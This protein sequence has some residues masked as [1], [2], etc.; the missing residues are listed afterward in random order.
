MSN[1]TLD[2]VP[3][4]IT[5]AACEWLDRLT[6]D[7]PQRERDAFVDWLLRSPIHVQ[8]F[9][10]VSAVHAGLCTQL[11]HNPSWLEALLAETG[12]NVVD[13][14][15]SAHTQAP[16]A[17]SSLPRRWLAL[18]A[19]AVV[20]LIG[21]ILWLPGAHD[22]VIATAIG[23]QR[24][25]ILADGSSIHL[26]T[27]TR[28]SINLSETRRD[29]E[30]E[31]GELMVKVAYDPNRPFTVKSENITAMALGTRFSVYKRSRNTVV[32][33]IEG[34][35]VV[36]R[37][38]DKSSNAGIPVQATAVELS[39]GLKTLVSMDNTE[40][41]PEPANLEATTAW[42]QRQLQF[43]DET[44]D[45]V[46]A[47]FNRYNVKQLIIADAALSTRRISGVFDANDPD[48]FVRLLTSL[49][50]IRVADDAQGRRMLGKGE[51][52]TKN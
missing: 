20:A 21:G 37:P 18:A 38:T 2:K 30:L 23:E 5:E 26:N 22:D 6:D 42:M 35:V 47:E 46:V 3:I 31:H 4:E 33:V 27:N 16:R 44:L 34:R 25:V 41:K 17:Q 36:E 43:E 1:N 40:F 52:K 19:T 50:P 12:A 14:P 28:I 39:A 10:N 7:S 11:R 15:L 32:T 48:A 8:Q 49:E 51:P 45:T 29:I 24:S 9:L 13:L